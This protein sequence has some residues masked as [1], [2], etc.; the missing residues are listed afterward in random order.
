VSAL[1]G[2][3]RIVIS[4]DNDFG[5][6]GA[7]AAPEGSPNKWKLIPKIQPSTGKQDDGEYLEI[8]MSSLPAK[9]STA[10]VTINVSEAH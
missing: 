4:N 1:E 10:T 2:G 7:E 9:T 5:I 6:S 3:K 8:N